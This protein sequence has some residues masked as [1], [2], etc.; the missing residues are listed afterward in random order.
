MAT[1]WVR[2]SASSFARMWRTW[3]F[4]VSCEMKSCCATSAF[5]MPSARSCRISRSRAVR[6]SWPSRPVASD[7]ISAG[8][9]KVSP[10]AT[11]SIALS[12][13]SCGASLRTYPCAPD[14]SPRWRSAR[15]L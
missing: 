14:S 3:L 6:I 8:S 10:P 11:F 13:V 9:T 2:V 12:R 5:D 4:T 7:G 15:S 1:A